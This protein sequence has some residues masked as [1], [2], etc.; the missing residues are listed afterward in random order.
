[1]GNRADTHFPLP[2]SDF[3]RPGYFAATAFT[4]RATVRALPSL[5]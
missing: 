4:G 1:M 3:A 5:T 2:I